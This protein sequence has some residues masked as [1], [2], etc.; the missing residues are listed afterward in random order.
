MLLPGG[1]ILGAERY[2]HLL[3][4]IWT[5][6]TTGCMRPCSVCHDGVLPSAYLAGYRVYFGHSH[7][8]RLRKEIGKVPAFLF[9]AKS[10]VWGLP[11]QQHH[12]VKELETL[13]NYS[14]PNIEE[15]IFEPKDILATSNLENPEE[16]GEWGWD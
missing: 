16:G 10:R 14:A 1:E 6:F 8:Q 9:H 7:V 2:H 13:L 3:R 4:K 5:I 15:L 12:I 11:A